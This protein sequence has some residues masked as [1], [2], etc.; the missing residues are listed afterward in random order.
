MHA[1]VFYTPP[2]SH[3]LTWRTWRSVSLLHLALCVDFTAYRGRD[4]VVYPASAAMQRHR[5][6]WRPAWL[7]VALLFLLAPVRGVGNDPPVP[8]RHRS[9]SGAVAAAAAAT[10]AVIAV[11]NNDLAPI[12]SALEQWRADERRRKKRDG[13]TAARINET[14]EEK[15]DRL[16]R[17]REARATKRSNETVEEKEDRLRKSRAKRSNETAEEKE[18]RLCRL[19]EAR[20]NKR[21]NE[22]AEEKEERLRRLRAA[23]ATKRTNETVEE[24]EDRLRKRREAYATKRKQ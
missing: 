14:A 7:L 3:T 6:A 21:S 18:D 5:A 15:E 12:P 22:T 1:L 23:R 20:A 10:C 17:L 24:K 4:S 16:C 19:R 8:K 9:A 11:C 13:E 2:L